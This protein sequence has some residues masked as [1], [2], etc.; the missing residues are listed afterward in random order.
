M[1]LLH[2][3]KISDRFL[4]NIKGF[5]HEFLNPHFNTVLIFHSGL[6]IRCCEHSLKC[7]TLN[8]VHLYWITL[9]ANWAVLPI[10]SVGA[11][12]HGSSVTTKGSRN[13]RR[14]LA[15]LGRVILSQVTMLTW[16]R[17]AHGARMR[18]WSHRWK[19]HALQLCYQHS[20]RWF[21]FDIDFYK[22]SMMLNVVNRQQ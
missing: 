13:T 11:T 22:H 15:I 21:Y 4:K 10:G 1:E 16:I 6:C 18:S 20:P 5:E 8:C 3:S 9:S 17:Q 7:M 19:T 2:V 14:K 12:P